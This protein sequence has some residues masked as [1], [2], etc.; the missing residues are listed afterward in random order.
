MNGSDCSDT[1]RTCACSDTAPASVTRRGSPVPSLLSVVPKARRWAFGTGLVLSVTAAFLPV[2]GLADWLRTGLFLAAYALFGT[3]V[4]A[5]AVRHVFRGRV[6]DETFLMSLA[7]LGAIAIGE[8]P[9]AVAVM[10][11]YQLG[12]IFQGLAVTRSRHAISA[13]MDLRPDSAWRLSEAGRTAV[14][15]ASLQPG[16]RIALLPGE[17][18]PVD[19][20]VDVGRSLLDVSMLTGEPMPLEAEPGVEILSGSVNRTGSLELRV[21]RRSADSAASRIL[22]LVEQAQA[23]K[24]S[25]ERFITRFARTYTPAVVLL[26][27]L[28]AF[29]PPLALGLPFQPWLYRALV[30]LVISCPCALVISIPLGFLGGIGAASRRGILVKGGTALEQMRQLDTVVFDKTGTLTRGRFTVTSQAL[31]PALDAAGLCAAAESASPHPIARAIRDAA[32]ESIRLAPRKPLDQYR[33]EHHEERSG[34]GVSAMV[35]GRQVLCGSEALL[36]QEG[37]PV[38]QA[39]SPASGTDSSPDPAAEAGTLVH[40]AVDRRYAGH[41]VV[42]DEVK[43]TAAEAVLLLRRLGVRTVALVT[44]DGE[45]AARHVADRAGIGAVHF[46]QLPDQKVQVVERLLQEKDALPGGTR[47]RL[48]FVGDGLN[49]APVLA[50]ADVGVAMG[51]GTDA[52]VESADVVLMHEDPR[53]VA[54]G[55]RIARKTH[56]IVV[57]NVI[58]ALG[59]KLVLMALGTAGL[60]GLWEAVFADVGVALLAVLNAGRALYAQIR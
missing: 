31:D 43:P 44:G 21:L 47:K 18:A 38:P 9:E 57:Q 55:I 23:R 30:F 59:V 1:C 16:D 13:L 60:S 14:D 3:D 40:V 20:V 42:E 51:G 17:R 37:I 53:R 48:A 58:L 46:R 49:D 2:G 39:V 36:R 10:A 27:S 32:A 25:T 52:A 29:G 28:L 24:A 56:A 8:Y 11:F 34:F 35:D 45:A 6:L 7:T 33:V 54:D 19:A 5:A 26:A 22:S 4:L 12:E 50:R 41:L 15:P